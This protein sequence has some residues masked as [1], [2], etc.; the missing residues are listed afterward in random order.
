MHDYTYE[1]LPFVQKMVHWSFAPFIFDLSYTCYKRLEKLCCEEILP[2]AI[3]MRDNY[4]AWFFQTLSI[5]EQL[6]NIVFQCWPP[7]KLDKISRCPSQSRS[8][9]LGM[10]TDLPH[11]QSVVMTHE[12]KNDILDDYAQQTLH[13]GVTLRHCS[14][15]KGDLNNNQVG[16]HAMYMC[17]IFRRFCIQFTGIFM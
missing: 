8:S 11:L 17:T 16:I 12:Y 14:A 6:V 4:L 2:N 7:R 13:W 15:H 10:E 9:W 5:Y 1:T 3:C